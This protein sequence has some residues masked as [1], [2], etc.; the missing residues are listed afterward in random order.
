VAAARP[1]DGEPL[2][3]PAL[4]LR[5]AP[6]G[7]TVLLDPL[8]RQGT[9]A[10]LA[11]LVQGHRSDGLINPAAAVVTALARYTDGVTEARRDDA[12]FGDAG[13]ARVLGASAGRSAQQVADAVVAAAL[14]SET[15]WRATTSRSS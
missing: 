11:R 10:V 12:F 13:I 8:E 1:S 2:T 5:H 9:P 3:G 4:R 15:A 14:D 7:R 6:A